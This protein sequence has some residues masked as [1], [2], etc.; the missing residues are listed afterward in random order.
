[1]NPRYTQASGFT[2][3]ELLIVIGLLGALASLALPRLTV[4]KTWAL[5][6]SIAPS[7]MM[8]IR[9]AYAAFQAD[10]MPTK[11]DKAELSTYGLEILVSTNRWSSSWADTWSFPE[12]FDPD[13]GKGWRG[14]YLRSEGTRIVHMNEPGQPTDGDSAPTT[15]I[16]VVHDPRGEGAD[17]HYYRVLHEPNGDHLALVFVGENGNLECEPNPEATSTT[18][19]HK[20]FINHH[21]IGNDGFDDLIQPLGVQ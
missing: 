6:T 8:E 15:A 11:T 7:E 5:D 3:I 1:M 19:F 13:R 16:P 4:Q 9:R 2:L 12:R 18:D 21:E 14:P 17:G 20:A 10:C